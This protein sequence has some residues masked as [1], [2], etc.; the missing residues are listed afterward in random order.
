MQRKGCFLRTDL[1]TTCIGAYYLE[2]LVAIKE[3]CKLDLIE[4]QEHVFQLANNKWL[5]SS[6]IV[7]PTAFTIRSSSQIT[8]PPGCQV[9]LKSHNIP[10]DSAT[11]DSDL[12]TIYLHM[13]G[14]P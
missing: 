9:D 3:K 6:P 1:S 8:V 13:Y 12:E 10:A 5:I 2:N 4:A 7:L 14:I 11:T